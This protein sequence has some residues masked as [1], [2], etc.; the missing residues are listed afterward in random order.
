VTSVKS[1]PRKLLL[2]LT[3]V[4]LPDRLAATG[5]SFLGSSLAL[6]VSSVSEQARAVVIEHRRV[7]F[8]RKM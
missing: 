8:L 3:A 4:R 6:D 7:M 1:F 2:L 5:G